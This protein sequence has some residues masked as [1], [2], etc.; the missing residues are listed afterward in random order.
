MKK[1][2]D[3]ITASIFDQIR[4]AGE[5][6]QVYDTRFDQ[7][8]ADEEAFVCP[9]CGGKLHC[10]GPVDRTIKTPAG[11]F[12]IDI[13]RVRCKECGHAPRVLL[14]IF[15]TDWQI[16]SEDAQ[17]A[18]MNHCS[19]LSMRLADFS[20]EIELSSLYRFVQAFLLRFPNFPLEQFKSFFSLIPD[21]I[22]TPVTTFSQGVQWGKTMAFPPT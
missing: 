8:K 14:D 18:L 13:C 10:H 1:P 5:L 7:F 16:S 17:K 20:V 6:Q 21:C 11:T 19:Q 2:F 4:S 22:K 3:T 12:T 9:E 15:I